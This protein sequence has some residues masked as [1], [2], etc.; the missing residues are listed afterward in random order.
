[1]PLLALAAGAG[2][3]AVVG[4]SLLSAWQQDRQR[5]ELDARQAA[6]DLAVALRATLANPGIAARLPAA[7]RFRCR[8]GTLVVPEAVAWVFERPV[9]RLDPADAG[10]LQDAERAEFVQ[11]DPAQAARIFAELLGPR[12]PGGTAGLLALTAAGFAAQ[13]RGDEAAGAEIAARLLAALREVAATDLAEPRCAESVAAA[14][15]LLWPRAAAESDRDELRRFLPCL[16]PSLALPTLRRLAELGQPVDELAAAQAAVAAQRR[17]LQAVAPAVALLGERAEARAFAGRLLLWWPDSG[18]GSGSDS[19]AGSG[20]GSGHGAWLLPTILPA[21]LA[22]DS[23]AAGADP[24]AVPRAEI[25]FAEPTAGDVHEIVAGLAWSVPL[26]LPPRPWFAGPV[27]ITAAAVAL[28][29]VG[30]GSGWFALRALRREAAAVRARAEFLTGV[31]HELKTPVAAIHLASEVLCDDVVP[32]QKLAEYHQL[33]RGE[34][35]RLLGLI[36]NVLD[37]GR[38]EA[39]ERPHD[40]QPGDLAELVRE[41]VQRHRPLLARAGLEIACVEGQTQV[42][43]VFDQGGLLQVLGNLLDNARKYAAKGGRVVVATRVEVA[44]FVVAVRDFGPGVPVGE[45]EAVFARFQR[46]QAHRHGSIPGLGLGLHLA[47][48]IA[49]RHGGGL[50]CVAPGDGPGALFELTLPL[51]TTAP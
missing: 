18:A 16:P 17:T 39:G 27:A 14:A 42:P 33:L 21:L 43:G 25:V 7:E 46:G 13:R 29:L 37:L 47:R 38:L 2:L 31:T 28:L 40:P 1:M 49:E 5:H 24:M 8:D 41:A 6:R 30:I 26:P 36:D 45:R 10:K 11:G 48:G 19:G 44:R 50:R 12:R 9:E 35:T 23:A 34:S 20:S 15:L 22:E 51:D 4:W 32:R 3:V